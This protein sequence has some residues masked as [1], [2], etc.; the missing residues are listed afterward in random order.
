MPKWK[1]DATEFTVGVSYSEEKGIQTRLPKPVADALGNPPAV[2]FVLRK[3]R[4]EVKSAQP[5]P[6]VKHQTT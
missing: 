4:V 1:K 2:T 6:T 3:E 5:K